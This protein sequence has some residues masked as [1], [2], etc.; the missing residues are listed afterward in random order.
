M[1]VERLYLVVRADLPVGLQ[2]AQVTHAHRAFVH[3]HSTLEEAWYRSSN[4]VAVL[5]ARDEQH[6]LTLRER[7]LRAGIPCAAFREPD[8]DDAMTALALAP[9]A[10]RLCRG[11]A[12]APGRM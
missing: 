9:A 7:A 11:L 8:L 2:M 1:T 4:T 6:L 3:E 10:K 5:A 12:V